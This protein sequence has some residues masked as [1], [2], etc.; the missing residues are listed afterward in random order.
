M[1]SRGFTALDSYLSL[2]PQTA[3]SNRTSVRRRPTD[4]PR[5]PR[6]SLARQETAEQTRCTPVRA[7]RLLCRPIGALDFSSV[8]A[9]P[10]AG[11]STDPSVCGQCQGPGVRPIRAHAG[12]L[13]PNENESR[14]NHRIKITLPDS[15][16]A[17]L[18]SAARDRGEPMARLATRLIS[19]GLSA[20]KRE[21]APP[22][23]GRAREA[24]EPYLG[25]DRRAPWLE[26]FEGEQEWRRNM[27]GAIVALCGRYPRELG[28]L[29]E[30]WWEH[31][32]HVE[33]LCALVL[34]RDWID[35]VADDPRDELVFSRTARGLQSRAAQRRGRRQRCLAARRTADRVGVT[36][37]TLLKRRGTGHVACGGAQELWAARASGVVAA[38]W[39]PLPLR[40][41]RLRLLARADARKP[42]QPAGE[43]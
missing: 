13:S 27:W 5:P 31:T 42:A 20:S 32:A 43:D 12:P 16:L 9:R 1:G 33:S 23:R 2:R 28:P 26:P 34:W 10:R 14:M 7:V 17:E 18:R 11:P 38:R 36:H 8:Y 6:T 22:V 35:Q 40:R 24:A 30:G 21:P 19:A 29:K 4:R 15:T 37:S 25:A 39:P 41:R 3:R